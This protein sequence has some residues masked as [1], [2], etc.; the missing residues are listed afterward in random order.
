MSYR[1]VY[2]NGAA[3]VGAAPA[4]GYSVDPSMLTG[5][6]GAVTATMYDDPRRR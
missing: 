5:Y 3:T 6:P 4:S 1:Y 2:P